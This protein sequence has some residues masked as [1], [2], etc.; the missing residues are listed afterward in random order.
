MPDVTVSPHAGRD[1]VAEAG[2]EVPPKPDVRM[3]ASWTRRC[4]RMQD[5]TVSAKPAVMVPAKPDVTVPAKPDV[6]M[7]AKPDAAVS[8]NAGRGGVGGCRMWGA[9]DAR[10]DGVSEAE[11]E[12]VNQRLTTDA[13]PSRRMV[14]ATVGLRAACSLRSARTP[15]IAWTSEQVGGEW[16]T[17]G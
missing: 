6:R 12:G 7:S 8:A 4:R 5:V 11:C 15:R 2:G 9:G 1:G 3:S 16:F 14:H 10:C 13:S 17:N